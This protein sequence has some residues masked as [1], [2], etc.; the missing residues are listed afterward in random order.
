MPST[1]VIRPVT[2]TDLPAI[3]AFISDLGY[4]VRR[5]VLL[6]MLGSMLEDRRYLLL[7]GEADALGAVALMSLS[8]RPVL[9]LQGWVGTIEELVVRAQAR[10]LGVGARMLQYA[11]GLAAERGWVRLESV[12]TRGRES[13]RRGFLLHR[14]FVQADSVTYRWGLLEGRY[15]TPPILERVARAGE[16]A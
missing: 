1:L 11:K 13:H 7:K 8:S 9:R 12:I 5:E 2:A 6:S 10:G 16:L 14:G 3:G 4:P 15:P